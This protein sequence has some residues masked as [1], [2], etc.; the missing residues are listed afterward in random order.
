MGWSSSK[1][2]IAS[3]PSTRKRSFIELEGIP[4]STARPGATGQV[5]LTIGDLD[6]QQRQPSFPSATNLIVPGRS[7]LGLQQFDEVR[8]VPGFHQRLGALAQFVVG[9]QALAPGDLLGR[10]DLEALP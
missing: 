3:G 2:S 5:A 1:R 7:S 6:A 9:E 8:A 10:A 4:P